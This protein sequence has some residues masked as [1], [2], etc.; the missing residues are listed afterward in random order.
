[1]VG[2]EKR[3]LLRRYLDQ[4]LSKAAVGRRA[5]L[6]GPVEDRNAAVLV[7]VDHH[8]GPHVAAPVGLRRNLQRPA[9]V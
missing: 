7:L 6:P 9:F 3:V 8:P 4:G 5:S 1:M 2:R